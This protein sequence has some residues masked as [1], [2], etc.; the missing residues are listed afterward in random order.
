[1]CTPSSQHHLY[2]PLP[3]SAS[4]EDADNLA[5]EELEEESVMEMNLSNCNFYVTILT[6]LVAFRKNLMQQYLDKVSS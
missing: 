1:M 2:L 4:K 6:Y 3:F 5:S